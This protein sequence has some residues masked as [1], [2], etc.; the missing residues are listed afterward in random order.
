MTPKKPSLIIALI[1][2]FFL[3]ILLTINVWIFGEDTTSGS[4]QLSLLFAASITAI[5]GSFYKIKFRDMIKGAIESIATAMGAL[6]ILLLIG[7]LAGTW[8]MS[9]IVPSMIQEPI[10]EIK[11][12]RYQI[13]PI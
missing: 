8:M 7:S 12:H 3:I 10:L 11:C 2:V 1:P 13:L 4:N 9:G 6:I 5:I